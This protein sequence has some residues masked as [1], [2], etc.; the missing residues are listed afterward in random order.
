M[1]HLVLFNYISECMSNLG[2]TN[3][4]QISIS[5]FTKVATLLNAFLAA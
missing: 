3:C 2:V 5:R 1:L 4:Y